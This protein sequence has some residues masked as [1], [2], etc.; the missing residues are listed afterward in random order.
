MKHYDIEITGRVQNVGFRA[1]TQK[2]A[3]ETGVNGFVKNM[4]DG[5]VYVEAEGTE[6]QLER[7]IPEIRQGPRWARVDNVKMNESPV[8]GYSSFEVR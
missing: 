3:R 5:S 7:F 6:E 4:P 2:K 1:F 8:D